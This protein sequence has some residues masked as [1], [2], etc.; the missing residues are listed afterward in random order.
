MMDVFAVIQTTGGRTLEKAKEFLKNKKNR[1]AVAAAAAVILGI[2]MYFGLSRGGNN[3]QVL[4]KA[5]KKLPD[6][7]SSEMVIGIQNYQGGLHPAF[8]EYSGEKALSELLF[9]P[10]IRIN[11]DGTTEYVLADSVDVSSDHKEYTVKLKSGLKYSDGS[12]LTADKV[13]KDLLLLGDGRSSFAYKDCFARLKGYDSGKL[14][15]AEDLEGIR[16]EDDTTLIFKFTEADPANMYLFTGG[17]G[18]VSDRSKNKYLYTGAYRLKGQPAN[19]PIELKAN[20]EFYDGE[21]QQ[22]KLTVKNIN[23]NNIE[24]MLT[25]GRADIAQFQANKSLIASLKKSGVISLYYGSSDIQTVLDFHQGKKSAVNKKE[26][27]QAVC[28]AFQKETFVKESAGDSASQSFSNFKEGSFLA[29]REKEA[30]PY[31]KEDAV[32]TLERAGYK[33]NKKGIFEKEGKELSLTLKADGILYA[34][35]FVKQFSKDMKA[36]GIKVQTT[37]TSEYDLYY[38]NTAVPGLT[39]VGGF[40]DE[41]NFQDE[42]ISA[43]ESKLKKAGDLKE[44]G[45]ICRELDERIM[46]QALCMPV[47][48]ERKFT[49]VGNGSHNIKVINVE[50]PFSELWK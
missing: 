49:A 43:Y 42:K 8:A 5:E 44:A 39:S 30:Y 14:T 33:K 17:I 36:V 48:A 27:R 24:E 1:T 41:R 7:K 35:L 31:S 46:E 23:S 6:K 11:A 10:L 25:K 9:S 47:Y 20:P 50:Q 34:D 32:K 28:Y 15:Q 16:V 26:V 13:K 37:D 29:G 38:H 22:K 18:E 45:G 3:A 2:A 19:L 21:A 4:Y 40:L 12:K